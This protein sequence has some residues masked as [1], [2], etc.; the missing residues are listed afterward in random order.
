MTKYIEG[1]Y[2]DEEVKGFNEFI[3]FASSF[4]KLFEQY[5]QTE[6]GCPFDVLSRNYTGGTFAN[7][8]KYRYG[9]VYND[10]YIEFS[11]FTHLR[12][13]W[14]EQHILPLFICF[15][16][17]EHKIYMWKINEVNRIKPYLDIR[18]KGV[19][20]DRIGLPINEAYVFKKENDRYRLERKPLVKM[21]S[22]EAPQFKDDSVFNND[23]TKYNYRN[24]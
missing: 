18:V 17:S 12:D 14:R 6:Y 13:M 5:K 8:L 16:D 20:C 23:I 21:N 4:P 7:E 1:L 9:K 22:K 19:E 24:L 15:S 10:M 2:T 3:L 11:K